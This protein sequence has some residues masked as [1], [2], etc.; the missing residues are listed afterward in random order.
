[1]LESEIKR[2]VTPFLIAALDDKIGIICRR[3]VFKLHGGSVFIER[4]RFVC[5]PMWNDYN[6][7]KGYSSKLA[8]Y[9]C[10]HFIIFK[11]GIKITYYL[12]AILRRL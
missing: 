7:E 10:I 12:G 1:M 3:M 9:T 2:E 4:R 6:L 8:S 11:E 5:T